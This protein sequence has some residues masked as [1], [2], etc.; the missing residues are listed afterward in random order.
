V[1]LSNVKRTVGTGNPVKVPFAVVDAEAEAVVAVGLGAW[2][3][4]AD[5]WAI[6]T[7]ALTEPV[8]LLLLPLAESVGAL[9]EPVRLLLLPL[10]ESVGALTEPVRPLLLL[11][12]VIAPVLLP[13]SCTVV[14][15]LH[16]T[17]GLVVTSV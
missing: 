2:S 6:G 14:G 7:G 17:S 16:R 4:N 3:E 12:E 1:T 8:R 10:A 11:W 9:T 5:V 13:D 15:E